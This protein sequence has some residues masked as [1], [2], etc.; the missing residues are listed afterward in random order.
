MNNLN[1]ESFD[2]IDSWKLTTNIFPSFH[3]SSKNDKFNGKTIPNFEADLINNANVMEIKNLIFENIGLSNEDLVFNGNWLNGKTL[4]RAKASNDNL[5]NF[6]TKFGVDEP[7][8]GGSFNVDLRLYCDCEPWQV[9]M[10][11]LVAS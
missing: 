11:K 8:I 5:S 6:L 1:V 10:K 7:V 2:N 9:S 4:L 3:L